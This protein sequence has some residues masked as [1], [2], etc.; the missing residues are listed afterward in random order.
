MKMNGKGQKKPKSVE[1]LTHI[2]SSTYGLL[3]PTR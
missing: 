3:K 2:A 1:T